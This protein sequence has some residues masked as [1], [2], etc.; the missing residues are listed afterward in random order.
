MFVSVLICVLYARCRY[1][2]NIL[3]F[4]VFLSSVGEFNPFMPELG[5]KGK[6]ILCY[7]ILVIK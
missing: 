5:A 1:V 3:F 2:L 7:V 4:A 6:K